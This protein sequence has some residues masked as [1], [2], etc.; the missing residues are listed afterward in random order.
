MWSFFFLLL[1]FKDDL[2]LSLNSSIVVPN[3]VNINS[4]SPSK[5]KLLGALRRFLQGKYERILKPV[6]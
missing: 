5:Q 6:S 1:F 2:M 4:Y 3:M